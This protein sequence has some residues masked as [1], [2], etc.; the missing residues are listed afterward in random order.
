MMPLV[1]GGCGLP[2][3]VQIATL[4][5]DGVS[6][7]ATQKT[8]GD[9]GLSIATEKDCALWRGPEGYPTE[10]E[11]A[12]GQARDTTLTNNRATCNFVGVTPGEY[13]VAVFHDENGNNDL[14]RNFLGIPS[15]GTGAS[16]GEHNAFGP[17]RYEGARFEFPEGRRVHRIRIRIRY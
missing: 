9:H 2:L 13:A 7:Y 11:R 12:V 5:A 17:P 14:D 4:L 10:R 15:E 1:L 3:G 8:L 6:L 16:S